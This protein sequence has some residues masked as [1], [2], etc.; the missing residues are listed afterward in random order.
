MASFFAFLLWNTQ[1]CHWLLLVRANV[2]KHTQAN[3]VKK[4]T[5]RHAT[6]LW[7]WTVLKVAFSFNFKGKI[8]D[9]QSQHKTYLLCFVSAK[10]NVAF[11]LSWAHICWVFLDKYVSSLRHNFNQVEAWVFQAWCLCIY[12]LAASRICGFPCHYKENDLALFSASVTGMPYEM[13]LSPSGSQV[14]GLYCV[15]LGSSFPDLP[16]SWLAVYT[17]RVYRPAE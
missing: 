11:R 14:P 9:H 3:N 5:A 13:V 6:R 15:V 4:P 7:F 12:L 1:F 2:R 17:S 10:T 8:R 16:L